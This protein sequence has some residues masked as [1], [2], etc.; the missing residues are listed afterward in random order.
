[1]P[2]NPPSVKPALLHPVS[3]PDAAN[4]PAS[5]SASG[6]LTVQGA[7]GGAQTCSIAHLPAELVGHIA[8]FLPFRSVHA[9]GS[10]AKSVAHLL[11]SAQCEERASR[12][13]SPA[14]FRALLHDLRQAP[15]ALRREAIAQLVQR[16]PRLPPHERAQAAAALR[17]GIGNEALWLE[18]G[19]AVMSAL[20]MTNA[21][22]EASTA[23]GVRQ[24]V[25]DAAL[26]PLAQRIALIDALCD[27]IPTLAPLERASSCRAVEKLIYEAGLPRHHR[28]WSRLVDL[29]TIVDV[30]RVDLIKEDQR[31]QQQAVLAQLMATM[32]SDMLSPN[33]D[34]QEWQRRL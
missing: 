11:A 3:S 4:T 26:A 18:H 25:A 8:T 20:D 23:R 12:A 7:H 2:L 5:A 14:E 33:R 27:H 1:M 17:G 9:L 19:A 16:L 28:S 13:R 21:V 29:A 24:L 10:T 6:T 22:L 15:L 32:L 34:L 31:E 30:A